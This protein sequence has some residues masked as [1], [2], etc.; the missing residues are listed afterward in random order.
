MLVVKSSH[1]N[2]YNHSTLITWV[3]AHN[4]SSRKHS[5]SRSLR[6]VTQI[7]ITVNNPNDIIAIAPK[8]VNMTYTAKYT[9]Q[10]KKRLTSTVSIQTPAKASSQAGSSR[11]P[12]KSI[13]A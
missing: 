10:R 11:E 6:G 1:Y 4:L 12:R 9:D 8:P 5:S 3:L 7:M 2:I 13:K